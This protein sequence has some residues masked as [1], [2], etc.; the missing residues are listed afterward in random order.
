MSTTSLTHVFRELFAAPLDAVT[1]SEADY[2]R[3]WADWLEGQLKLVSDKNGKLKPGVDLA[4][5]LDTAPI[6]SLDGA[7]DVAITMR[8][9]SVNEFSVKG[10]GGM[11]VGPVYA[12]GGFG[13]SNR[14]SQESLFQ[15]STRYTMSN[16]NQNLK[17]YLTERNIPIA[18]A[19]DVNN[20]VALLR[21]K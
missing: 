17:S 18:N 15:A 1:Q 16:T 3:I 19:S 21:G 8:I 7:I 6:I 13:F 9:A 11:G 2:R 20:A 14:S 4:K 10:E 5:L 12:S